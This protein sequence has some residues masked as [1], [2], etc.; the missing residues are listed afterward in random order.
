MVVM[1]VGVAQQANE[2]S[3]NSRCAFSE[4]DATTQPEVN[5]CVKWT[6]FYQRMIKLSIIMV[7]NQS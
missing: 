7:E 5:Y 3:G 6:L 1:V 4:L 2:G